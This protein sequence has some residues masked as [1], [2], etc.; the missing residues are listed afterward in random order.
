[1]DTFFSHIG[2]WVT[3]QHAY[4]FPGWL[5]SEIHIENLAYIRE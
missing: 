3:V 1:M 2:V 4:I 5:D